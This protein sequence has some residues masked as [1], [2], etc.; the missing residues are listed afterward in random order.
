MAGV[1][2]DGDL[3]VVRVDT[4]GLPRGDR[5]RRTAASTGDVVFAVT[6]SAAGGERVSFGM[7]SGTERAFRGPRGRRIKGSLEHTAPLPRGSSGQ[8]R[9]VTRRNGHRAQHQPTRRRLLPRHPRRSGVA[10]STRRRSPPVRRGPAGASVSASLR[11]MCHAPCAARSVSRSVTA[12]WFAWSRTIRAAAAAGIRQGDLLVSVNGQPVDQC[13]RSLRR[14]RRRSRRG[15]RRASCAA[16]RSSRSPCGS[17][18]NRIRAEA[19]SRR[20]AGNVHDWRR[21]TSPS[22]SARCRVHVA[23]CGRRRSPA[24]GR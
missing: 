2:V 14:A 9:R 20:I 15:S 1:D 21:R 3:A 12:C 17:R 6:R 8:S 19:S 11:C 4:G 24:P 5:G 22:P 10:G 23:A 18:P 7:V 13:R 16:P